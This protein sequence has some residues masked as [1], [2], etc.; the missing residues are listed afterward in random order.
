MRNPNTL[1]TVR[2][3][4]FA[5]LLTVT[6]AATTRAGEIPIGPMCTPT[7]EQPCPS[8]QSLQEPDAS[9]EEGDSSQTLTD[10]AVQVGEAVIGVLLA[11]KSLIS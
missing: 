7:P 11:V 2:N 6:T 4:I 9:P 3:L 5:A 10:A 8:S 1:R